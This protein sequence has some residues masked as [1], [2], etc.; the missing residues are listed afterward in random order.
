MCCPC[1]C[2][3]LFYEFNLVCVYRV[4]LNYFSVNKGRLK[5]VRVELQCTGHLYAQQEPFVIGHI[6]ILPKMTW[7]DVDLILANC[8]ETYMDQIDSGLRTKKISRLDPENNTED[9]DFTLGL[10]ANSISG[11]TIGIYFNYPVTVSIFNPMTRCRI[12]FMIYGS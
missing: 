5:N 7:N 11:Y 12:I 8:V 2:W 6:N 10:N 4:H 9:S 3:L 1:L